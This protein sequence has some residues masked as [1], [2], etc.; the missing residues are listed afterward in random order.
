MEILI[1]T[2][3]YKINLQ[4]LPVVA[5]EECKKVEQLKTYELNEGQM[6]VGGVAG[7]DR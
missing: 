2:L 5:L 1:Q 4:K 7:K 6:C 3:Y